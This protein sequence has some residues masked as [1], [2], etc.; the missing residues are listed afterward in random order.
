M[1]HNAVASAA[2][3]DSEPGE[4]VP[5]CF[6]PTTGLSDQRASPPAGLDSRRMLFRCTCRRG[7]ISWIE[8]DQDSVNI[9]AINCMQI[10]RRS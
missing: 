5:S 2:V 9:L 8:T 1:H 4:K 10:G 7:N 6:R 3:L